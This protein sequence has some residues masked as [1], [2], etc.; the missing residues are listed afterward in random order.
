MTSLVTSLT[1]HDGGVA[2]WLLSVWAMTS[3]KRWSLIESIIN[4]EIVLEEGDGGASFWLLILW[5]WTNISCIGE[6][7][8]TLASSYL[9]QQSS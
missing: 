5:A 7:G 4:F 3:P 6:V 9:S 2:L 1:E 8:T